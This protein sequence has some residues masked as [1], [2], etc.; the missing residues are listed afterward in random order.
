V[1]HS[2]EIVRGSAKMDISSIALT[3]EEVAA[4]RSTAAR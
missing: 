3:P 4:A 1:S 2:R